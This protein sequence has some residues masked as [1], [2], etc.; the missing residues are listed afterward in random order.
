MF[1]TFLSSIAI[2]RGLLKALLPLVLGLLLFTVGQVQAQEV[3]PATANVYVDP[4]GVL[5]WEG[6]RQEVALFGVNYT[7]PFAY[8]YRAHRKLGV[9]LEQ[10]IDQDVYH[11][12]RLGVNAFRVHVWD[13]E[14]T[15]TLGN[16]LENE[17]LRL[18][19][20]L[21]QRLKQ[22]HIKIVL[23]PIA[24]WGNGY[25]EADTAMT[26]FSSIYPKGKAYNTPRAIKAQE[27][28]LAQ[29]LNHRNTYT[30]QLNREDPDIIAYE[31][32]NE[33]H[34]RQPEAEVS[35]FIER[36]VKAMRAT[37]YRKPIFY[38]IAESPAV[39]NAI[40][41]SPV[42]G[43]TFQWYPS[44]LVNGHTL[45]GNPLPFVDQYPIPYQ[46]DPRFSGKPRLVY[47]FES[48][49][50][51][52]PVMYLTMARSFRAAG[53]QWATQFAYDPLA[54][55][56]ANTEY[57]T[58]YLNL[59]YTPAKA[60]SLLIAGKVFR[61]VKRGQQFPAY[62]ADTAF[63]GFRV[64]YR[65]GLSELNSPTEFYYTGT[66]ATRPTKPAALR[67]VA[68]T[69]SSPVAS[70]EGTGAYFL[71]RV[72]T[73]IWRLEVMPDATAVRDPFATTSLRQPVTRIDW[74]TQPMR[75]TL[76]GLGTNYSVRA[77]NSG[78][79]F[80]GV[81]S[82]ATIGLAP[83][84]Y[85][86]AAKGK[87][88]S[89]YTAQTPLGAIKLG[90]FVAPASSGQPAQVVH[91]PQVQV[92]AGRPATIQATIAGAS[93]TDSVLLIAQHFYGQTR[94]LP[95]RRLTQTTAEAT[96]PAELLY[97][98]LLRYW[99]VLRHNGRNTTFP[100][101]FAG[102]P[103][104]WDYAPK[105]HWEAPIVAA[106]T[107]LPLFRASQ[108]QQRVE[109]GG[110]S[111]GGWADYITTASGQ[112]ALRLLQAPPAA[113][114]APTTPEAPVAFLR[115]YFGDR[116]AARA[117]EA[118]NF[119]EVVLR[120]RR[121]VGAGAVQLVLTTQDAAAYVASVELGPEIQEV[122]VPLATFRL[123]A[124]VLLPRAYPGFL[125]LTFRAPG[126]AALPITQA[127]ALQVLLL[128]GPVQSGQERPYL[129]IESIS[130]Q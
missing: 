129:D 71:D 116:L 87:A 46:Q 130:L 42:D 5:R 22:R 38:N 118:G 108:D 56:Y 36:M 126:P 72:A 110:I 128:P 75:L 115:A 122:R 88:T 121:S 19:D 81:A 109:A 55:A 64:S 52:N 100:G 47:E 70:Y 67:H 44:G 60:L 89:A 26:G 4:A 69:G 111:G 20:Y 123:G 14:I 112:L 119:K 76:P 97:P 117:N 51:L 59:A 32:C 16:L 50:I 54:L 41:N 39:S 107:P 101:S 33:P 29:F 73:G 66:T 105:E 57:Q 58:H 21:I 25:P 113:T 98:G 83:G 103:R 120:A 91:T 78:N 11:L 92:A 99:I 1:Q 86:V 10:A 77:I 18:L 2:S 61:Q 53:F 90:E 6:S 114:A 34:Y 7:A 17:H 28:Y 63:N 94:Q 12:S 106:S 68:G 127:E 30:G 104:D 125:P 62:P 82:N 102:S 27:N 124:Q 96:V 79:S 84:V 95:M 8:S 43:F 45:R 13:V 31:V 74:N 23:T 65:N 15:D 37:G 24:Y 80:Q 35:L 49:D 85:L 40:L 93:P 3:L 48:G 9:K